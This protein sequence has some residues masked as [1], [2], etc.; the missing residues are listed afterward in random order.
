MGEGEGTPSQEMRCEIILDMFGKCCRLMTPAGEEGMAEWID[1][2]GCLLSDVSLTPLCVLQLD[3]PFNLHIR[4][5][6]FLSY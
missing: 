1:N 4:I 6:M 2:I 5:T 3:F